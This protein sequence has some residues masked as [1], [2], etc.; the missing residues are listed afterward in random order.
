MK[1]AERQ[2]QTKPTIITSIVYSWISMTDGSAWYQLQVGTKVREYKD[3]RILTKVC[4]HLITNGISL[5][6]R[7]DNTLRLI[8]S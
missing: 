4:K 5:E 6:V 8:L 7:G 3:L 2:E 1:R